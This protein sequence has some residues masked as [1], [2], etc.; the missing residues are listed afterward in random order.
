MSMLEVRLT[1]R[2][3][4]RADA[5]ARETGRTPEQLVNEAFERYVV[6]VSPARSAGDWKASLMQAAGLWK[7]PTDLP[8]F[9]ALRKS[10]DRDVWSR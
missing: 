2:N 4:E 9:D 1:E 5:L 7:D 6:E 8:D 10:W 3:S